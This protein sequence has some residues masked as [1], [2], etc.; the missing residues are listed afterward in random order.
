MPATDRGFLVGVSMSGG[1]T[2]RITQ[3]GRSSHHHFDA[4]SVYLRDF[5]DDYRADLTGAF[6]FVLVEVSRAALDSACDDRRGA[7]VRS[8]ECVTGMRDQVL[9]HLALALGAAIERPQQAS[10]LF[11]DQMSVAITTYLVDNYGG[12]TSAAPVSSRRLSRLHEGRAKAMLRSRLD[13][14]V[15]IADIA[16]ACSLSRSYFIRAFRETTG[17]T[18]LQWLLAERISLARGLLRDSELPLTEVADVCGF[19]DQSHFTRAFAKYEGQP[20]GVW[21]RRARTT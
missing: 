6:D 21:R 12:S 14:S 16:D 20:P 19:A 3:N 15:S 8:L 11:I 18:P 13:G 17:K 4:E 9:H 7:R 10:R 2:R 1:H 5:C